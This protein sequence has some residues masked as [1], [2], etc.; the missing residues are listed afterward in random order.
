MA[1]VP[2]ADSD[3]APN[4]WFSWTYVVEYSQELWVAGKQHVSLTL[5]AVALAVL[6]AVPLVILVR[7]RPRLETP[8][9][10][11]TGVL[12]TI[13][14]LAM[15]S[16]LWPIFGLQPATVIIALALYA[17]LV[18]VRNAIVGLEGVSGEVVEA[19]QAMGL[20][21]RQ[22]LWRVQ[23]PLALPTILAGVRIATVSTVGMVTIGALVGYGGF[24]SLILSGFQQNFFHAQIATATICCVLLAATFELLLQGLQRLVT[25]WTAG[26]IA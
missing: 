18:I 12:Y 20:T 17:L 11:L 13:P 24:G 10:G 5:A 22:L 1:D 4:P 3:A 25:P 14:S 19:A 23:L 7:R 6:V 26:R 21:D 2:L 9:V 8:I 15:M 16:L